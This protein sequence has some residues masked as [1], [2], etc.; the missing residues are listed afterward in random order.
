MRLKVKNIRTLIRESLKDS[1]VFNYAHQMPDGT[2]VADFD[3]GIS[4]DPTLSKLTQRILSVA[5]IFIDK[6]S[7]S[8][9]VVPESIFTLAVFGAQVKGFSEYLDSIEDGWDDVSIYT[10]FSPGQKSDDPDIEIRVNS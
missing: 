6:T 4:N 2:F 7:R 8:H 9:V 3:L 1:S 10:A 5:N